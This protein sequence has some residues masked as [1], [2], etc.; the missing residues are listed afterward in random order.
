M[1][2]TKSIGFFAFGFLAVLFAGC[3]KPAAVMPPNLN[4][5]DI[6]PFTV[7]IQIGE[8]MEEVRSIAGPD[9]TRI[10][11]D[12]SNIAQLIVVDAGGNIVAFDEAR[13]GSSH[14]N[15]AILKVESLTLGETYYFLLLMGHWERDYAKEKGISGEDY[16]YAGN[17]PTLL[18]AGM[19]EQKVTGNGKLTIA[20]WPIVVDTVFISEKGEIAGPVVNTGTPKEVVLPPSGWKAKWTIKRGVTGNGLTGLIQAQKAINS[21]A[22]DALLLRS[23]KTLVKDNA[24]VTWEDAVLN[25]NVITRSIKNT[26]GFESLG[27]AGSVNFKLE[28]VPFNLTGGG[29]NPWTEFDKKSAFNL[30]GGNAPV[31]IIRNGVNDEPQNE[32][33]DF[34]SFHHLVTPPAAVRTPGANG[35]GAVR[36]KVAPTASANGNAL[37]IRNEAFEGPW[38]STTPQIS[39]ITEG[40]NGS[41]DVYYAVVE[42]GKPGPNYSD[43]TRGKSVW[44]GKQWETISIPTAGG[45]Y[46]VYVIIYKDGKVSAPVI[47]NTAHPQRFTLRIIRMPYSID[48]ITRI[49]VV[50]IRDDRYNSTIYQTGHT[51]VQWAAGTPDL[52]YYSHL[53]DFM[54]QYPQAKVYTL[55]KSASAGEGTGSTSNKLNA[56]YDWSD[57]TINWPSGFVTG[58]YIFFV[59]GDDRI[60]GYTNPGHLSPAKAENFLFF[61]RPDYAYKYLLPMGTTKDSGSMQVNPY[62]TTFRKVIPIGYQTWD[63]VSSIMKS[64]GVGNRPKHDADHIPRK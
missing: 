51:G 12:I 15:E 54:Q 28:Y 64:V 10:K 60:R 43:Y 35:N 55:N 14:E 45:N 27:N 40:F 52:T 29:T 2:N 56:D 46:D 37:K 7:D 61:L 34:N 25:G 16:I 24:N 11:G 48:S 22:G 49:I 1:K 9:S 13:R 20:M 41:A 58:Y 23:A 57:V 8:D 62:T 59:E 5:P 26:T 36:Y 6:G 47:I 4:D 42:A 30:E 50:P 31:W 3:F 53:K 63:N 17:P 19:K 33:T 21:K 38:N 44:M 32:D 39:F 18:A